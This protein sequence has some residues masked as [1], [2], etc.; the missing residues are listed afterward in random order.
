MSSRV[1][2]LSEPYPKPFTPY[3]VNGVPR[4][5]ANMRPPDVQLCITESALHGALSSAG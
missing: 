1:Q 3:L 4:G 2:A 5:A